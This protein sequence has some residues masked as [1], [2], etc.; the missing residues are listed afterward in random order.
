MHTG[1]IPTR[2]RVLGLA[3]AVCAVGLGGGATSTP[4]R[5]DQSAV[6]LVLVLAV[7][8]SGSVNQRRFEL[9]RDGYAAA[10]RDPRV[11]KAIRSQN[12]S[13]NTANRCRAT[14]GMMFC[15]TLR[16]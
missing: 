15:T 4:A 13:Q 9:Q 12:T 6:D 8:V 5:A 11:L 7:D 3:A 16:T 14:C 10:F 1:S 2:R